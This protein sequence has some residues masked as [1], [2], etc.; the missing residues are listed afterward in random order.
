M[1][2]H[3]HSGHTFHVQARPS[4][5]QYAHTLLRPVH[6]GLVQGRANV[7]LPPWRAPCPLGIGIAR[8]GAQAQNAWYV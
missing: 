6:D 7:A 2:Y 5:Q 1:T 8:T 4:V 3:T